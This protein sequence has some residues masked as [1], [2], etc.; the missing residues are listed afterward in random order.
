MNKKRIVRNGKKS[1]TNHIPVFSGPAFPLRF[2]CPRLL[3]F[4]VQQLELLQQQF[5]PSSKTPPFP[6]VLGDL[7]QLQRLL[8]GSQLPAPSFPSLAFVERFQG[9]SRV[10]ASL[11][12]FI[13]G[14]SECGCGGGTVADGQ[15]VD[16]RAQPGAT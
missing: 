10:F 9:L 11:A 1:F 14:D 7:Q 6:D 5:L 13:P 12:D 2:L 15:G 8:E 3:N 16:G 4:P